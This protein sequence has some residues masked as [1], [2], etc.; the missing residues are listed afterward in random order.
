MNIVV[1][2]GWLFRLS[3]RIGGCCFVWFRVLCPYGFGLC[4]GPG[5]RLGLGNTNIARI[6]GCLLLYF[7]FL[8][9][10]ISLF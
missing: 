8:K 10:L 5:I 7:L 6:P 2:G 4:I 9:I 3:V 1:R